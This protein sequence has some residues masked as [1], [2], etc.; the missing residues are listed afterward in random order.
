MTLTLYQIFC[1]VPAE[2][3]HAV[4]DFFS[5]HADATTCFALNDEDTHFRITALRGT[6]W[7]KEAI[8]TTLELLFISMNWTPCPVLATETLT[9]RDWVRENQQSFP[10]IACGPLIIE[11]THG[12]KAHR[13]YQHRLT[14]DAA[15]AFGTGRHGS[16]LGCL[17]AL[18]FLKK[19]GFRPQNLADVGTGTGILALAAAKLWPQMPI[20][21]TD[22]DPHAI[23]QS[24]H[25]RRL[26]RAPLNTMTF[27]RC[28]AT[29]IVLPPQD[30]VLANILEGPL[31]RLAKDFSGMVKIGGY[32]ILSGFY[33]YQQ[34]RLRRVFAA[35]GFCHERGFVN[36]RWQTLVLKKVHHG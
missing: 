2:Q 5:Q 31:F 29:H 19:Q 4:E 32:L 6:P 15:T 16:T 18:L 11:A 14:I 22:I 13:F 10:P 23:A 9:P 3:A 25:N 1:D 21:G 33:T 34:T 17:K 12:P 27:R 30:L 36:E 24:H 20:M 8:Q 35:F 28:V 7:R 26:N